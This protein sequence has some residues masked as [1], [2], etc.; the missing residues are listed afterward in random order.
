MRKVAFL[1]YFLMKSGHGGSDHAHTPYCYMLH[2]VGTQANG[3]KRV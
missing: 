1:F 2:V 3:E